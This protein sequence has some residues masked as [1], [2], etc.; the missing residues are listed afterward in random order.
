MTAEQKQRLIDGKP[1]RKF[2]YAR[3]LR[4]MNRPQV[5]EVEAFNRDHGMKRILEKFPGT[6]STDWD[7]IQELELRHMIGRVGETLPL[8]PAG[9]SR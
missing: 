9:V 5:I 2:L 1:V 4:T 3:W 6:L 8:Y 7:F